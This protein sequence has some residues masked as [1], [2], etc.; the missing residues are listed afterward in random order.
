MSATRVRM[1]STREI[2]GK[3]IK[4]IRYQAIPNGATAGGVLHSDVTIDLEDGSFLYF[5]TEE[6]VD[7]GD[8]GTWVG[9]VPAR[10]QP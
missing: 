7:G 5:R 3:R 10:R 6:A 9:Y 1:V 4:G 2:A 8:Y